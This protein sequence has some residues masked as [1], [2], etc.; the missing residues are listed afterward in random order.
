MGS[1]FRKRLR[2]G[3]FFNILL[4]LSASTFGYSQPIDFRNSRKYDG[5]WKNPF[6]FWQNRR[7]YTS[8]APGKSDYP[9]YYVGEPEPIIIKTKMGALS[10]ESEN[11]APSDLNTLLVRTRDL[12]KDIPE[13]YT[14]RLPAFLKK[15]HDIDFSL[16]DEGD[17]VIYKNGTPHILTNLGSFPMSRKNL[18]TDEERERF[19]PVTKN[20]IRVFEK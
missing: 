4:C 16:P 5:N 6:S 7:F 12:M 17:I 19:L 20:V 2:V 18:M 14:E 15:F 13:G 9:I 10:V 1:A 8:P 3:L 11:I